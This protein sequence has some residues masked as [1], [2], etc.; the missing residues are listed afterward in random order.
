MNKKQ[1]H[2]F[3][4]FAVLAFAAAILTFTGCSNP[5]SGGD[6]PA[7]GVSQ[8]T[9]LLAKAFNPE[10]AVSEDGRTVTVAS[11]ILV[12]YT[13][14]RGEFYNNLRVD[15]DVTLVVPQDITLTLSSKNLA[16][17][18]DF[19]VRGTLQVDGVLELYN[20]WNNEA[21]PLWFR[22]DGDA[23]VPARL[24]G[25]GTFR[26]KDEADNRAR[27]ET[28]DYSKLIIAGTGAGL[29]IRGL[30]DGST[31]F[32]LPDDYITLPADWKTTFA[33]KR[34]AATDNPH[35][36]D[37]LLQ[38]NRAA[39]VEASNVL[40]T[41][42]T[43]R[44]VDCWNGNFIMKNGARIE[45]NNSNGNDVVNGVITMES[46]SVIA[47][48][49]STD[50]IIDARS[51]TMKGGEIANNASR[52]A[53]VGIYEG[54]TFTMSGGS[55]NN[56]YAGCVVDVGRANETVPSGGTFTMSGGKITSNRTY[57][58]GGGVQ[59]AGPRPD[60]NKKGG[61]FT[62]SGGVIQGNL[63]RR[64]TSG[65]HAWEWFNDQTE[66]D[67]TAEFG[68]SVW[69]QMLYQNAPDNTPQNK[70]I[71]SDLSG[72]VEVKDDGTVTP[73]NIWKETNAG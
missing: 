54:R 23:A 10:A 35:Q 50:K 56:N 16:E 59:I 52:N 32:D 38:V 67:Q 69:L 70:F 31:D 13:D 48:N 15:S 71:D 41:G 62:K 27:I 49:L 29:T 14:E 39:I 53:T 44:V 43:G 30:N 45:G 72:N 60:E 61:T 40:F 2:L 22:F 66:A 19:E 46:G 64:E 58:F 34:G 20:E 6:E 8:A 3:S 25:S 63:A 21:H 57:W 65:E 11:S 4:S 36:A 5:N 17:N 42:Y 68:H 18:L 1:W 55:I 73:A 37:R 12:G 47:W 24:T 26:L 28:R 7:A 33:T 51:L 9:L